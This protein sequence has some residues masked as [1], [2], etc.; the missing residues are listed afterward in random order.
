MS[1]VKLALFTAASVLVGCQPT[2]SPKSDITTPSSKVIWPNVNSEVKADS[3]IETF[4]AKTLASMTLEQKVAQMM[5]PEIRD[6]TVED[7]RK[8]GFGSYLNGGG[9]FPKGDKNA[10]LSAWVELADD[11]YMASIDDSID[12]STIPTMWGT[13]AVHGHNNLV[14]ATLFPHNIGLGAM[15]DPALIEEIAKATAKEVRASGIDWAFAPTVATA[16]D[17]RWGRTYESYSESPQLVKDYA[18]AVV[19]GIQGRPGDTF[20]NQNHVISSVK[21]FVGDGGTY[22]GDDQGDNRDSE[23]DLLAI[24]AQGYISGLGAGAQ[25]VMASFNSWHGDK[26][27]GSKYLLTDVLK[28]QM[29]FDGFVVGDWAGHGQVAGCT[30]VSC[31]QAINAGLDMFMAPTQDWKPLLQNTIAQVKAGEIPMSRIDDAVT[32]ILR[33]KA[34]FGLFEQARPSERHYAGDTSLLGAK[35]HREVARSAVRKSLVLL[36]NHN[37]V[38]PLDPSL[39]VLVAGDGADN[40]TKQSGGWT[41]TWQG[42]NNQNSDFPNADSIL[43]GIREHVNSA[44]G[45]LTFAIDGETGEDVD[46]AIVVFGE[47]PYA[48]GHGDRA[49]VEYQPGD[50]HDLALLTKL[51][52]RGIPVVSVFLSGR[53]MWVNPE[54]NAS[55]AFVA[56]WLPGSE[57]AGVADVLFN[58]TD[59]HTPYPISGKLSFSWPDSPYVQ[60][61]HG[62]G[63]PV[64][65]AYDYG[66]SYGE[67][68]TLSLALNEFVEQPVANNTEKVLFDGK[69][70]RPWHIRL[71]ANQSTQEVTSNTASLGGLSYRTSD[72]FIQ[73]DAMRLNFE[74][75][76]SQALL[77]NSKSSF[78]EDLRNDVLANGKLTFSI[79][80][81]TLPSDEVNVGM[82]CDSD[83]KEACGAHIALDV[84]TLTKGQ[85]YTVS[86]PLH[87]FADKGMEFQNTVVPFSIQTKGKVDL[88]L[89]RVVFDF[90]PDAPSDACT[91]I[92]AE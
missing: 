10:P 57:G 18:K 77:F 11:M 47:D 54:L 17:D 19:Y 28:D 2:D 68:D 58:D 74:G 27:H 1:K 13:D 49:D 45:N 51:K 41:L 50:K 70:H 48:E 7:M 25:I 73:E 23:Q 62:D 44:G 81:N 3:A 32:R 38:L 63:Q 92:T 80:L 42:T 53:P 26:V 75:T 87:C 37:N 52:N 86:M 35:D 5:Q 4:I 65:F 56:A 29:G 69:M 83:S 22:L 30:N 85:W 6:I 91:T 89:S 40:I 79:R 15:R 76:D 9:S 55:D 61:N 88:S 39:N 72:R 64:L 16:R 78:R 31:P 33:V 34:R 46:V 82:R 59:G 36:K 12:G 84:E 14:G 21:H 66:L 67:Q 8:Y 43:D 60:A 71:A 20:L 90:T 24:H